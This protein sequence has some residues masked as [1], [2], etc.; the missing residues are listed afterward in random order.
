MFLDFENPEQDDISDL[1]KPTEDIQQFLKSPQKNI[2]EF[3]E[4]INKNYSH[5]KE[6]LPGGIVKESVVWKKSGD[7]FPGTGND[8]DVDRARDVWHIQQSEALSMLTCQE[9]ILE[10][11]LGKTAQTD[12][13]VE[14]AEKNGVADEFNG[15]ITFEN[16]GHILES[17]GI[18]AHTE[19]DAGFGQ[20]ERVL[21][22]GER[23]IVGVNSI[24]LDSEG[25]YPMWSANHTVEVIGVDR[26]NPEDVRIIINDPGVEDGGART[27]DYD[28]FMNAWGTSD[29]FL[30]TAVRP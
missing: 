24:A 12:E 25:I 11:Y 27:V 2:Y 29:G 9:F 30:L 20:L 14:L 1:D 16:A 17:Y 19:Y 18:E 28:T 8:H 13:L 15:A 26:S 10:E 21:D 4:G 22:S 3:L 5:E 6:E 23:A 7:F